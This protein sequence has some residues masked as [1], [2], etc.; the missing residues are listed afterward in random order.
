MNMSNRYFMN[1]SSGNV[2]PIS[3][4]EPAPAPLPPTPPAPEPQR[5]EEPAQSGGATAV[6]ERPAKAPSS[7][8]LDK[9]P[10][11]KVLLHN[12]DH[13]DQDFV[14]IAVMQ[15]AGVHPERAFRI[16]MEAHDTGVGLVCVT[17]KE[18]AEL[19]CEQLLSKG[20]VA[21]MEPA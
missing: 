20:L 1:A 6:A 21:T 7:P 10:P 12:D 16:M 2:L 18:L 19:K 15:V 4:D 11:F 5:A 17:H 3:A 8:K 14:T 9:M 13:N